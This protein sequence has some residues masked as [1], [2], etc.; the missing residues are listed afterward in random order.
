M[1]VYETTFVIN[2]QTDDTAIDR[3]VQAVVDKIKEAGGKPTHEDRMGTRRMAYEI[4]GLSQGYYTSIIFEAPTEAIDSLDRLY[5][6]EEAYIRYMTVLYDGPD[7]ETLD[8][9]RSQ[10]EFPFARGDRPRGGRRDGDSQSRGGPSRRP[11]PAG[12]KPTPAADSTPAKEASA[13]S[14]PSEPA[15]EKPAADAPA[16]TA[17]EPKVVAEPSADV[18]TKPVDAA[19]E[20]APEAPKEEEEL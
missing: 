8:E 6:L 16:E 10:G 13:E 11:E 18:E 2:P 17:P 4:L 1:R 19:P 15:A 9:R 20:A 3:Q 14:A 7:P 12:A 5:K